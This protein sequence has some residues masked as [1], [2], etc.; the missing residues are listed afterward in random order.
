MYSDIKEI[1]RTEV[2]LRANSDAEVA[3]IRNLVNRS[4][5]RI[6][7]EFVLPKVSMEVLLCL[8]QNSINA[9]PVFIGDVIAM[10][11][12]YTEIPITISNMHPRY[13]EQDWGQF[14]HVETRDLGYN[15]LHTKLTNT[16][17]LTF[18][19]PIVES[20]PITITVMGETT[21]AGATAEQVVM[22]A[23]SK[24]LTKSF[25]K[26]TAIKKSS[27][28]EY[29]ITVNDADGNEVA[30]IPNW[31]TNH[32]YKLLHVVSGLADGEPGGTLHVEC[33]YR[34]AFQ[35]FFADTDSFL[36]EDDFDEAIAY[37]AAYLNMLPNGETA[38]ATIY[39]RRS[40]NS[41]NS[42]A[43]ARNFGKDIRI[44]FDRH[45]HQ[46]L[47]MMIKYGGMDR[48]GRPRR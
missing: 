21:Q 34:P 39:R 8:Q 17:P 48:Y 13:H 28:N 20:S 1:L 23:T 31:V 26:V 47:A 25:V 16:A 2:G 24:T 41:L 14:N 42:V 9:L 11:E 12:F 15:P 5:K 7:E 36:L 45:R 43:R 4:A 35:P 32:R 44:A 38:Q 19:T 40:N 33:H 6:H 3:Y 30:V 27:R 22:D 29:D 10:R 18:T 46:D 37:R